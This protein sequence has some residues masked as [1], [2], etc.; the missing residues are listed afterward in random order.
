MSDFDSIADI[1]KEHPDIGKDLEGN[2][3]TA[4]KD[5]SDGTFRYKYGREKLF[6]TILDEFAN[7]SSKDGM[8]LVGIS[9][10]NKLTYDFKLRLNWENSFTQKEQEL[11]TE[12]YTKERCCL[13]PN[14]GKKYTKKDNECECL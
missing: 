14:C 6:R 8:W 7:I 9:N 1:T 5:V 2:Y 13:E 12:K 11:K 4:F 10:H 3:R